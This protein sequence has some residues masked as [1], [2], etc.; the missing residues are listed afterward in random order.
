MD[1]IGANEAISSN[2]L[3]P[4]HDEIMDVFEI[5]TDTGLAEVR[6]A[7]SDDQVST[8]SLGDFVR[9]RRRES[10]LAI[11]PLDFRLECIS[12]REDAGFPN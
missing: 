1:R 8:D 6:V 5:I 7:I 12:Y 4:D 9:N 10:E 2:E 3:D 11:S